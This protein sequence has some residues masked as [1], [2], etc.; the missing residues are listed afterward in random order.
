[1]N[2]L[3]GEMPWR[4]GGIKLGD[5][6]FKH[7]FGGRLIS[8]AAG[9]VAFP[10]KSEAAPP[11]AAFA[12]IPVNIRHSSHALSTRAVVQ[13]DQ[14]CH[15]P[16]VRKSVIEAVSVDVVYLVRRPLARHVKPGCAVRHT[17]LPIY[18]Q[19]HIA[20][21]VNSSSDCSRMLVRCLDSTGEVTGFGIVG[22]KLFQPSL[23]DFHGQY[24]AYAAMHAA[25]EGVGLL[26]DL[27]GV[28]ACQ[29]PG[30]EEEQ[31]D[32]RAT[33]EPEALG[34]LVGGH[35]EHAGKLL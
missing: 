18:P 17:P 11:S 6:L 15:I 23:R 26:S 1:M 21:V 2:E 35:G 13:V 7:F 30:S 31:G 28:S 3:R 27:A 12:T 16:E 22:E 29:H 10:V 34:A 14:M 25:F 4:E 33:P 9:V 20:G 8:G 19:H 32:G 24:R 5:F